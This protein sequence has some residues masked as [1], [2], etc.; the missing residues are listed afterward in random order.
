MLNYI[1][2]IYYGDPIHIPTPSPFDDEN[3]KISQDLEHVRTAMGER[4]ARR[5]TGDLKVAFHGGQSDAFRDGFQ[6]G[7]QLMLAILEDVEA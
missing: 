4:F 3:S 5:L 7:G 6:L 1:D 2:A